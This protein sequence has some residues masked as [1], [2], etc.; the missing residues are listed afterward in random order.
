MRRAGIYDEFPSEEIQAVQE[1]YRG[2]PLSPDQ[3]SRSEDS[4]PA[5]GTDADFVL[6]E[7][8]G[9]VTGPVPVPATPQQSPAPARNAP[10]SP[11]LLGSDPISQARNAEIA[12]RLSGQ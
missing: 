10:P 12:Q 8:I 5:L 4:A 7:P 1:A 3:S 2:T 11:A 9:S 6:P